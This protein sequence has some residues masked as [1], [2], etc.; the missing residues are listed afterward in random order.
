MIEINVFWTL[1]LL[2]YFIVLSSKYARNMHE[3]KYYH[4]LIFYCVSD[5]RPSRIKG[6]IYWKNPKKRGTFIKGERLIE[7]R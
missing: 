3:I 1:N 7:A 4:E 6:G 2:M 5:K